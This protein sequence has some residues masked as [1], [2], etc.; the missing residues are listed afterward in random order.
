MATVYLHIGTEKTGTTFIQSTL[1]KNN[2]LL[3]KQGYIYPDFGLRFEKVGKNRNGHFILKKDEKEYEE[4]YKNVLKQ[5]KKLSEKYNNIVLSDKE[6]WNKYI[7]IKYLKEELDEINVN[8]KIVVYLKRQDL[9][10]QSMFSQVVKNPIS[11]CKYISFNSY[12]KNN[13]KCL[14]YYQRCCQISDIVGKSNLIVRVYEKGQFEGK[15]KDL[16]SDFLDAIGYNYSEE[17]V[18]NN[19]IINPSLSGIYLEIKNMLNRNKAFSEYN[20]FIIRYLFEV[21]KEKEKISSY[22][23]NT[24]LGYEETIEII[25]KYKEENQKVAREFLGREDGILFREKITDDGDN[26]NKNYERNEYI[27]VLAKIILKQQQ[28][29]ESMQKKITIKKLKN[30]KFGRLI[31]RIISNI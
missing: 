24:I 2:N 10:L 27:D 29:I 19:N 22:F 13:K 30:S 7:F 9:F 17:F 12:I 21:K 11:E 5:I 16:L 8:L 23:D 3:E 15:N 6:C 25:S 31:R 18:L 4:I 28:E 26:E 20:S 14:N 1:E